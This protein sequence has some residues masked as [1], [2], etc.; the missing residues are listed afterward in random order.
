LLREKDPKGD[1]NGIG[2]QVAQGEGWNA[3]EVEIE[4]RV[5]GSSFMPQEDPASREGQDK[6]AQGSR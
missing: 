5:R 1:E 4:E 6:E 3:Q 2:G